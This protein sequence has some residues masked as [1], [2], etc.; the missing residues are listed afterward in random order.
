P[1]LPSLLEITPIGI[2]PINDPWRLRLVLFP[3]ASRAIGTVTDVRPES[4]VNENPLDGI[5]AHDLPQASENVFPVR[6][7]GTDQPVTALQDTIIPLGRQDAP[8]GVF[9]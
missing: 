5:V 6:R 3:V 1:A 2:V 7:V 8:S 9:L 4:H